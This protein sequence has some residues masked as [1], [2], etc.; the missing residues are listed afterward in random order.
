MS[1]IPN[2]L[3]RLFSHL[4]F[5]WLKRLNAD[6]DPGLDNYG[7]INR[8]NMMKLMALKDAGI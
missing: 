6:N 7:H 5:E 1:E 3:R 8:E 2:S 4:L